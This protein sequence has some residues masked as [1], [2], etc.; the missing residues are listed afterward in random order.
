MKKHFEL[1]DENYQQSKKNLEDE[2]S[3]FTDKFQTLMK[4]IDSLK[5]GNLMLFEDLEF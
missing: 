1:A 5:A 3:I 2:R 4:E